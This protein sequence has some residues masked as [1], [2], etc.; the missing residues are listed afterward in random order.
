MYVPGI[1]KVK[2]DKVKRRTA[3]EGRNGKER[4]RNTGIVEEGKKKRKQEGNVQFGVVKENMGGFKIK[5]Y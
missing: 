3:K 1:G 4:K 2:S 5:L